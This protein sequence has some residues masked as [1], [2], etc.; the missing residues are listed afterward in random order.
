[1]QPPTVLN[2]AYASARV[3]HA[4]FTQLTAC[5]ISFHSLVPFF[6]PNRPSI[7]PGIFRSI[8]RAFST[9]CNAFLTLSLTCFPQATLFQFSSDT[10]FVGQFLPRFARPCNALAFSLDPT[11]PLHLAVGLSRVRGGDPCVLLWDTARAMQ[12]SADPIDSGGECA[13]FVIMPQSFRFMVRDLVPKC[14]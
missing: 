8:S 2:T 12:L 13:F 14:C 7:L 9:A 3:K 10:N 6:A 11:T 1:M 5:T 4:V